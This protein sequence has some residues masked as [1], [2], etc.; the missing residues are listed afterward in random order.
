M[1]HTRKNEKQ[2]V[3]NCFIARALS[4]LNILKFVI[5]N[6]LGRSIINNTT[7]EGDKHWKTPG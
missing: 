2:K 6:K 7:E 1:Q 4:H 3:L 5:V